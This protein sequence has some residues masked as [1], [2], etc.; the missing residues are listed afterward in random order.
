MGQGIAMPGPV[1][2]NPKKGV[3]FQRSILFKKDTTQNYIG[4]ELFGSPAYNIK[5]NIRQ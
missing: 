1:S 3:G 5:M 2:Q 4:A